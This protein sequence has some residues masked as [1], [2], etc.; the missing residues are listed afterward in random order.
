M[1][2]DN[3]VFE[4]MKLFIDLGEAGHK[5]P[6]IQLHG[7]WFQIKRYGGKTR[8]LQ[9]SQSMPYADRKLHR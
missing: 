6:V 2:A 9:S 7:S 8:S 4:R 5:L 3:W 1:L